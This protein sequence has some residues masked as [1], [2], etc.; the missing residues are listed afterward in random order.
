M[1]QS[2]FGWWSVLTLLLLAG[3]ATPPS[4]WRETVTQVSTYDALKAGRYEGLMACSNLVAYGDTG[5]GT[6]AG[7]DGEMIMLSGVVYR[8]SHE[9][10]VSVM[11]PETQIPFACVTWFDPDL[12]FDSGPLT[13]NIFQNA[14]KWKNH[15]PDLVQG[16]RITGTFRSVKV[17]SVPGQQTP[18]PPLDQ[19]V[20]TQ[21]RVW[22]HQNVA[23][24]MVGFYFPANF[25]GIS[26][27]G[28]HLHFLS[29]DRQVGGHVLDFELAGGR[30]ALDPTPVVQIQLPP[31]AATNSP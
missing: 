6:F 21:Q 19:V 25:G 18:Y 16:V 4:P 3:C 10:Q 28:Y 30:I 9:G 20:A 17:R 7:L 1:Q 8:V 31:Q 27:A 15:N 26:P 2:L 11:P 22:D 13:Q 23:G 5:L 29:A 14:M 12:M 24:T